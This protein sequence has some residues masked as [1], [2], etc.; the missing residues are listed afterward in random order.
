MDEKTHPMIQGILRYFQHCDLYFFAHQI[1]PR[2]DYP[3][4]IPVSEALQGLTYTEQYLKHMLAENLILHQ[5]EATEVICILKAV[6]PDYQGFYLNL[7]ERPLTNA[8]GLCLIGEGGHAL[9]LS[10]A[11]QKRIAETMQS[12][13]HEKRQQLLRTSVL[14][15]CDDMKITD[16]W[17][18]EYLTSFA[19][20]LL[21]RLEAA[22]DVGDVSHLFIGPCE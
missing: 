11:E 2:V 16:N 3:L 21:P 4:L 6:A 1:P 20:S 9:H 10:H 18:R 17:V 14:S 13:G 19:N 8:I 5:F 7:C 22:L 15:L 12:I